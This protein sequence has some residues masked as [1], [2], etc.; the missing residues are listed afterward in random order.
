LRAVGLDADESAASAAA[1]AHR[2]WADGVR[3]SAET[4]ASVRAMMDRWGPFEGGAFGDLLDEWRSGWIGE[5]VGV[6]AVDPRAGLIEAAVLDAER[7]GLAAMLGDASTPA[8]AA[9][10]AWRRLGE[11][12]LG[13]PGRVEEFKTDSGAVSRLLGEAGSLPED[14]RSE[15]TAELNAGQAD[16]WLVLAKGVEDWGSFRAA[17][18]AASAAGLDPALLAPEC[19]YNLLVAGLKDRVAGGEKIDAD[20]VL[21]EIDRL[22]EPGGG[23][24]DTAATGWMRGVTETLRSREGREIDY[25]TMGPAR[26][27]WEVV[28]YQSGRRLKYTRSLPGGGSLELGFQLIEGAPSGPCYIAETETPASV[29]Y[30]IALEGPHA[31]AVLG[32]M[33]QDWKQGANNPRPGPCVW[34]WGLSLDGGRGIR[35]SRSWITGLTGRASTYAPGI[36]GGIGSPGP[37]HPLQRVS[38]HA[39]SMIAALLGCRLPTAAEWDAAYSSRGR[40]TADAGG[41]NLRDQTFETQRA[42]LDE[43]GDRRTPWP[44]LGIFLPETPSF[45]MNE[46][47][48]SHPWSDGLLWF[49]VVG[50]GGEQAYKH[51]VGNVAEYVLAGTGNAAM[52]TDRAASPA[53]AI[54]QLG[55]AVTRPGTFAVIGGSALSPPALAVDRALPFD[56][57]SDKRAGYADVGF[58]LAFSPSEKPLSAVLEEALLDAPYLRID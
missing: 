6:G 54:G 37:E 52:F 19:G 41:W 16:R 29:L 11:D 48:E 33:Q 43:L 45:P 1:D 4:A 47:A 26:A 44:D 51:L 20:R 31:E 15:V 13:W 7:S 21:A 55:P 9:Y 57:E 28:Q 12:A 14:R 2:A 17:S 56:F 18:R 49:D 53:D 42:Y 34:T 8:P 46:D 30:E 36:A 50:P 27:G 40:P 24:T 25:K 58:R 3:A 22:L 10:L 35:A 23:V 32:V 38:P 5:R 39:A